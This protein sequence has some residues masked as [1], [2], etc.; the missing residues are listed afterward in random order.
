MN[1]DNTFNFP[2][3]VLGFYGEGSGVGKTTLLT[4]LLPELFKLGIR[5]SVI[6]HAHHSFEIDYPGKDSYM[7]RKSGAIQT[8]IGSSER[9]ALI[10]ESNDPKHDSDSNAYLIQLLNKMDADLVDII[11][12]EGFRNTNIPKIKIVRSALELPLDSNRDPLLIAIATDI[13]L[14][15]PIPLLD[16]NSPDNIACFIQNWLPLRERQKNRI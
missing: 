14:N 4:K 3:P 13:E 15:C 1:P 8:M 5:V 6:K 2:I 11:L 10:T 16:L 9:W 7:L 12:V